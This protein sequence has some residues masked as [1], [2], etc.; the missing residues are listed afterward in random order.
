[1]ALYQGYE[2][3]ELEVQYNI[4]GTI[5]NFEEYQAEYGGMS[6]KTVER[7]GGSL[8]IAYGD[9]PLQALDVFPAADTGAPILMFVH[10]GYWVRGDKAGHRFPADTFHKVGAVW[11][12][13][14]YRLAPAA[15][16]DDIVHDVRS[17]AAWLYNNAEEV[18]GDKERLYVF[19]HSAGGHL[20]AM[21]LAPD[22]PADYGI[23]ADAIKGG[24][25]TS[26]LYDLNPFLYTSQKE[27]LKLDRAG[28]DR[29]SP[30]QNLPP[31]GTPM[32]MAWGGK[33]TDEFIRQSADYANACRAAGAKVITHP[34]PEHN[35]FSLVSEL[36]SPESPLT[37]SLIE[38]MGL[39]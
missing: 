25:P 11:A 16:L 32:V 28:V 3:D 21:T 20:T 37:A 33:E 12:P 31:A 27:Y 39:G 38:M 24:A 23:P 7:L 9:D 1:M 5:D 26:G 6:A 22:W 8:D 34:Y 14:N 30:M 36:T 29:L 35:H 4:A 15:S 18:G 19:G 2:L 17:A 13:V 10:G